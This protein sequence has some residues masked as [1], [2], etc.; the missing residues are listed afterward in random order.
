MQ[1][2]CKIFGKRFISAYA[3]AVIFVLICGFSAYG[4]TDQV[5]NDI[6]ESISAVIKDYISKLS[7]PDPNTD[8]IIKKVR[9]KLKSMSVSG[10]QIDDI[11][12]LLQSSVLSSIDSTQA[13]KISNTVKETIEVIL[14]KSSSMVDNQIKKMDERI[15][16]LEAAKQPKM[17]YPYKDVDFLFETVNVDE[18]AV[19]DKVVVLFSDPKYSNIG[20]LDFGDKKIIDLQIISYPWWR[21]LFGLSEGTAKFTLI[22]PEKPKDITT[23]ELKF[24]NLAPMLIEAKMQVVEKVLGLTEPEPDLIKRINRAYVRLNNKDW[25][26][27]DL[28]FGILTSYLPNANAIATS[29]AVHGY[30]GY[31]RFTPEK[32]DIWRRTSMFFAVGTGN[33]MDSSGGKSADIKGPVLSAGIGFDIVKGFALSAGVSIFSYKAPA[34]QDYNLKNS[35]TFGI[36]L[37]SDLWRALF[38]DK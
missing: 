21:R 5:A 7:Q 36:T 3:C 9:G 16:R 4:A 33:A 10:T 30:L 26:N 8:E 6:A 37:N 23:L 32:L 35:P 31:R 28:R 27:D 22:N 34:D 25:Q 14:G 15:D 12:K 20:G 19:A 1:H 18:K 29:V 11:A 24:E 38:N 2:V 13:D 17:L